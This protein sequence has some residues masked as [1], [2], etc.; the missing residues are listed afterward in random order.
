M[1]EPADLTHAV[2][3]RVAEFLRRLPPEQ[4][5]ALAEG[6]AKLE[7]AG[8]GRR[9]VRSAKPPPMQAEQVRAELAKIGDRAAAHRW[10]VDQNLTVDQLRGLA[11]GLDVAVPAK[12]RKGDVLDA[13]VAGTVGR[14][15]DF[16]A[17]SRPAPPRF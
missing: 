4:L 17:V 12:A 7:I 16:E 6:T 10:L 1:S 15:L 3:L 8:R 2:L 14:R 11:R 5:A 9:P 13:I